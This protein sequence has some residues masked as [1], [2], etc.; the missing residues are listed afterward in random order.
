MERELEAIFAREQLRLTA[1]RRA[2]F[3]VLQGSDAPL[4]ASLIAKRC[5]AIDRTSIYRSVEL[6]VTLG[7]AQSIP[8]GWKQRYE[9]TGPFKSHHHHLSCTKCGQL[10]DVKSQKFEQLVSAVAQE[11]Q[12]TAKD[13]TFEI[14]GVC[15]GC[16]SAD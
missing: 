11:Y 12:F 15:H 13:H 1:P 14:R 9:L 8:I 7:I 5:E 4:S 16:Q 2:V 6:F 10:I 3:G